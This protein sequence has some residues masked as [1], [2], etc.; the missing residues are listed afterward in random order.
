MDEAGRL[1][2]P[3]TMR[4]DT[5]FDVDDVPEFHA[6]RLLVL[7]FVCGSG[8]TH[9]LRGRTKL[10][11]LDFF[12]RYPSFLEVGLTRLREEGR[13]VPEYQAGTEGVEASMVRY[14]YGPWDHRYYNLLAL[15]DAR[16]LVKIGGGTI[17]T[18]SLTDE[19]QRVAE[20]LAAE[21]AFSPIVERCRIVRDSFAEMNGTQLKDFVYQTF[22]DE[23]AALPLGTTIPSPGPGPRTE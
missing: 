8:R 12:V 15:L 5:P 10:A 1:Q 20:T 19:G 17:E 16:G 18:Y 22:A 2:R 11:K 14:R 21:S 9:Q 4:F 6:A 23:V 3:S 13:A 7:M